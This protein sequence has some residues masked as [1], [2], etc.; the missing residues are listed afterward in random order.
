[1]E[2]GRD[3]DAVGDM[4]RGGH[5]MEVFCPMRWRVLLWLGVCRVQEKG[6][7]EQGKK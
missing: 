4:G 7:P 6:D 1:M 3:G 2:V 5:V